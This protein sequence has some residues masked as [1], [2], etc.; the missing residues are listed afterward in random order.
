VVTGYSEAYAEGGLSQA[1][2]RLVADVGKL[3]TEVLLAKGAGAAVN[4]V[5]G[6]KAV[7]GVADDAVDAVKAIDKIEDATDNVSDAAGASGK[8]DDATSA[9]GGGS[10]GS[11]GGG[12]GSGSPKDKVIVSKAAV[13]PDDFVSQHAYDKHRFKADKKSTKSSTQ[14][15]EDVDPKKIGEET[16]SNP[17]K[18]E[19][20]HDNDGNHYAT[21]YSK[22]FDSN[23]STP[24]TPTNQSRVII[25]HK[26]PTRSTQFPRYENPK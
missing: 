23:I 21:R 8:L 17:D 3:A 15:G 1:G 22:E 16:M 7:A 18:V 10:K 5:K 6:G 19:K 12:G 2:G 4:A 14:Y 25:N 26:D 13:T 11:S 24:D 20:L 9:V